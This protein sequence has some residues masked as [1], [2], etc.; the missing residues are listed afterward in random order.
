MKDTLHCFRHL[1]WGRGP[2]VF[3]HAVIEPSRPSV[4]MWAG[5]APLYLQHVLYL[6]GVTPRYVVSVL[7][8]YECLIDSYP[9]LPFFSGRH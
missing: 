2:L 4:D 5:I 1:R 7:C 3:T 6:Y 8:L 9:L